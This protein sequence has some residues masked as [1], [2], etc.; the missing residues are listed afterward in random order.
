MS[1]RK[2]KKNKNHQI[3]P[4]QTKPTNPIGSKKYENQSRNQCHKN[5]ENNIKN[6]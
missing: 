6:Q 5:K 4:D 2:K 3:K 1:Q